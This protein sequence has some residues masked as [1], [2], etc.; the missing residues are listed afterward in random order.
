MK[1]RGS[2]QQKRGHWYVVV[3]FTNGDG[4]RKRKWHKV[5]EDTEEAAEALRAKLLHDVHSDNYIEPRK[6]SV[7]GFLD[8]WL[9]AHRGQVRAVSWRGYETKV[10]RHIKPHIGHHQLQKLTTQQLN[11]FYTDLRDDKGLS[12][13]TIKQ[14]HMVI[15]QACEDAVTWGWLSKNPAQGAKVPKGASRSPDGPEDLPR[16][17]AGQVTVFLAETE[18]HRWHAMWALAAL[19]GMR[20]S[21]LVALCW[22]MVD[23]DR[24]VVRVRRTVVPGS[25]DGGVEW[26]EPKTKRSRRDIVLDADC[27]ALLRDHRRAQ[28]EWRLKLGELWTDNTLVFPRD[29]GTVAHPSQPSAAFATAC[30]KLGLPNIGMHGLRHTH[31]TLLLESGVNVKEVSER[32]GHSSTAFTMDRYVHVDENSQRRAAEAFAGLLKR[33]G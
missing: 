3:S 23:L 7:G 1:P 31:A 28:S 22:D 13:E 14:V 32:L 6:G 21:E 9:E 20:R 4:T 19:T 18:G 27:V 30:K 15:R 26:D 5:P 11:A 8:Q 2:I 10:R 24:G 16:W 12:T 29:D 33:K 25:G 17:N